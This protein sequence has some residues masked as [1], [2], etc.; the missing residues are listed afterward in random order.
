MVVLFLGGTQLIFMGI[1][2]EYVGRVFNESKNR[3]LYIIQ[4]HEKTGGDKTINITANENKQT[5]P[6][7]DAE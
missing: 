1:L 3:P 7:N 6:L 5:V 4:Q 2:G